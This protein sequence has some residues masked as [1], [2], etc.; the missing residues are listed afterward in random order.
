MEDSPLP[1][2]GVHQV[3]VSIKLV[4][5]NV[6]MICLIGNEEPGGGECF[7]KMDQFASSSH[8]HGLDI[9]RYV[10]QAGEETVN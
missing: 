10:A 8:G 7:D 5:D 9:G 6:V 3:V 2:H 1:D 4:L